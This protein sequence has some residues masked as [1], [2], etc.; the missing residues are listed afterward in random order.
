MKEASLAKTH[1]AHKLQ[2]RVVR[3]AGVHLCIR[4]NRIREDI[5]YAGNRG[6]AWHSTAGCRGHV[7]WHRRSYFT[8]LENVS[9]GALSRQPCRFAG[10]TREGGEAANPHGREGASLLPLTVQLLDDNVSAMPVSA[11]KSTFQPHMSLSKRV[12][13]TST[14]FVLPGELRTALATE[15]VWLKVRVCCSNLCSLRGPVIS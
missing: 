15:R 3:R 1:G 2:I 13:L 5:H 7:C 12:H 11:I 10:G 6:G 14:A 4:P 8:E 9:P